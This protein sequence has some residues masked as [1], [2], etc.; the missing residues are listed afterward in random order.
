MLLEASRWGSG[1][2]GHGNGGKEGRH[3]RPIQFFI[4]VVLLSI[5]QRRRNE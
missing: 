5:S 3:K 2:G 4:R 1:Y